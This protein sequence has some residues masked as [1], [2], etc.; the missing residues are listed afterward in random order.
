MEAT[1]PAR[2]VTHWELRALLTLHIHAAGP[3]TV[4][5]L[6]TAVEREGWRLRGRTSKVVS[7]ALRAEVSKGWVRRVARGV[8]APGRLPRSSKSRLRGRVRRARDRLGPA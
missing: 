4:A 1:T 6:V 8:Y 7:D 2:T 5:E 3:T